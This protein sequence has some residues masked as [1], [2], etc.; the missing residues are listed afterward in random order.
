[1]APNTKKHR[2]NV[3]LMDRLKVHLHKT[4]PVRGETVQRRFRHQ[5][6]ILNYNKVPLV[7]ELPNM[8][9]K[10]A[11]HYGAAEENGGNENEPSHS[12]EP[13]IITSD[14]NGIEHEETSPKCSPAGYQISQYG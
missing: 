10:Y 3:V 1:M 4:A 2:Q 13:Q 5:R 7:T 6:K 12:N 11:A 8:D 14:D 9:K